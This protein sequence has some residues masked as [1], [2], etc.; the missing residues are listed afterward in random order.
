MHDTTGHTVG[1]TVE[2]AIGPRP[3]HPRHGLHA[4]RTA[5]LPRRPRS[6]RR[7]VTIDTFRPGDILGDAVQM[8]VGRDLHTG[9]DGAATVVREA[10]VRT[11][12]AYRDH[13]RLMSSASEPGRDELQWLVGR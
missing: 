8:A 9:D 13:Y 6:I 10:S 4:P 5:L 7:T 2:V 12:L 3:I 11:E 1:H